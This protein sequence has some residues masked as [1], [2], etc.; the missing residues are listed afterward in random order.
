MMLGRFSAM[1][2]MDLRWLSPED[3]RRVLQALRTR[4]EVDKDGNVSISGVF[5]A[6]ITDLL[7][8]VNAPAD[9]PYT[10]KFR[11]EVPDPHP[12]VL[13]LYSLQL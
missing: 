11:Y 9:E 6:Y 3:R 8:M 12:G 2:G 5:E 7:P 4:V 13:T 10:R 1:R